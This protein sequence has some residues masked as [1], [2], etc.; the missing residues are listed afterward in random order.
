M[1]ISTDVGADTIPSSSMGRLIGMEC[2]MPGP[3]VT[4][5]VKR[6][7]S[8]SDVEIP[9][10]RMRVGTRVLLSTLRMLQPGVVGK[11]LTESA[12]GDFS[13][14]GSLQAPLTTV[15]ENTSVVLSD[16][17]GMFRTV[18]LSCMQRQ[19]WGSSRQHGHLR[20]VGGLLGVAAADV[21]TC[22]TPC[23]NEVH[24]VVLTRD[25]FC[26]MLLLKA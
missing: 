7:S 5:S 20:W 1:P 26:S 6:I 17:Y 24:L 22:A 16:Q 9:A 23:K 19:V 21:P 14:P 13:A 25:I 2:V 15:N 3:I 18:E 4:L 11:A 10:S 12:Q 8:M